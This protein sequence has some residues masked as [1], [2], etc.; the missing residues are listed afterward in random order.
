M[1][2]ARNIFGDVPEPV[3]VVPDDA[4]N[5]MV[6]LLSLFSSPSRFLQYR[7]TLYVYYEYDACLFIGPR[8][9]DLDTGSGVA[10]SVNTFLYR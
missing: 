9:L 2:A 4:D 7:I 10:T 1:I 5:T 8:D 6:F 3:L